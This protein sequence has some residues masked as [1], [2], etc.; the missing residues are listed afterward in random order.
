MLILYYLLL[1]ILPFHINGFPVQAYEYSSN[2]RNE[3][4]NDKGN[5]ANSYQSAHAW[6]NCYKWYHGYL[7]YYKTYGTYDLPEYIYEDATL[8]TLLVNTS[9]D[10]SRL[11]LELHGTYETYGTYDLPSYYTYEE[12]LLPSGISEV[13][14][15]LSDKVESVTDALMESMKKL[16]EKIAMVEKI[17]ELLPTLLYDYHTVYQTGNREVDHELDQKTSRASSPMGHYEHENWFPTYVKLREDWRG[18]SRD[19]A[20]MTPYKLV[21]YDDSYPSYA[22]WNQESVD[23]L[24]R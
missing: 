12:D 10:D 1:L 2:D 9:Y 11:H 17:R 23:E 24:H 6:Y 21:D 13:V 19:I 3:Y 22:T 8:N 18:K 20:T 4:K 14:S 15:Y 7:S 16:S 5:I